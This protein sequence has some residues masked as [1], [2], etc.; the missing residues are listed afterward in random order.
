MFLPISMRDLP[1]SHPDRPSPFVLSVSVTPRKTQTQR[2]LE[3][4]SCKRASRRVYWEQRG[5]RD[6]LSSTQSLTPMRLLSLLSEPALTKGEENNS[7]DRLFSSTTHGV[8]ISI[9]RRDAPALRCSS[10]AS[11]IV[12]VV[13]LG[14]AFPA[15]IFP[16]RVVQ[17]LDQPSR[18]WKKKRDKNRA[19]ISL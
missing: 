9:R 16:V 7:S 12:E 8:Q 17:Q 4:P 18:C 14:V 15:S 5:E 19:L 3:S 10:I 13:H 11:T 2:N 1:W 6:R